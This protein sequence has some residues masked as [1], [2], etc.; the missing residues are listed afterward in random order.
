MTSQ[1][2]QLKA[3]LFDLGGT[4]VKGKSAIKKILPRSKDLGSSFLPDTDPFS[5]WRTLG[6]W[7][8]NKNNKKRQ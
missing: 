7:E 3:V 4:L 6:N 8:L 2:S 1:E 5:P